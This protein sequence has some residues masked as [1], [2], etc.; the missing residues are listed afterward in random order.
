MTPRK[1]QRSR[2]PPERYGD[3]YI[4][5][6]Y[7]EYQKVPSVFQEAINCSEAEDWKRA[8]EKEMENIKKMEPGNWYMHPTRKH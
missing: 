4:Y 3:P 8:M 1:S 5:V 2:K 6:N 7:T